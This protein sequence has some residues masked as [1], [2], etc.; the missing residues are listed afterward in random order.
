MLSSIMGDDIDDVA[1]RKPRAF[2]NSIDEVEVDESELHDA[3]WM[4]ERDADKA[5][6][7][8][9]TVG[10]KLSSNNSKKSALAAIEEAAR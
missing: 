2:K 4:R 9:E 7:S 1:E 8:K 10:S 6:S 5:T 3:S